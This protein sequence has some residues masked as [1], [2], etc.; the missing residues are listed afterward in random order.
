MKKTLLRIAAGAGLLAGMSSPVLGHESSIHLTGPDSR[1][2]IESNDRSRTNLTTTN[3]VT[4]ANASNQFASTGDVNARK[5]TKVDGWGGGSG[6]ARNSNSASNSVEI[7]ND[8][9]GWGGSNW[10]GGSQDA[11]IHLTGPDSYNRISFNNSDRFTSTTRNNVAVA[12]VNNQFASSGDVNH[13]RNT[14]VDGVGGS[15]NAY[16]SNSASNDVSISNST[17]SGGNWGGSSP[18]ASI[19]T[20]G[21]DSNNQIRYNNSSAT[22]VTT[23][24]NVTAVNYNNQVASTGDVNVSGNTYVSGVGG[25]GDASNY[26]SGDNSVSISNN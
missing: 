7:D 24:N 22:N 1:N 13:Y 26:N 8:N 15:G 19:S 25:S 18:S 14:K 3:W 23:T 10:G 21:P 9:G 16:N 5:N 11:S 6:D 4:A 12:N 20:T 17:P 2:I